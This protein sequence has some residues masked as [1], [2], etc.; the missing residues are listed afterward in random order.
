MYCQSCAI[1][2]DKI[3]L[4]MLTLLNVIQHLF[5][6]EQHMCHKKT[7]SDITPSL[8]MYCVTGSTFDFRHYLYGHFTDGN[9]LK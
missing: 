8:P 3:R 6:Q 9:K 4:Q 2:T 5:S 1:R 7:T